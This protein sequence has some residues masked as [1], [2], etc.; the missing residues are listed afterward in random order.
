[1]QYG[2]NELTSSRMPTARK[3]KTIPS[4]S[5]TILLNEFL[6]LYPLTRAQML[7][8][9]TSLGNKIM[10]LCILSVPKK[11]PVQIVFFPHGPHVYCK[12]IRK[13]CS[14]VLVC[15]CRLSY[16]LPTA[17]VKEQTKSEIK[18]KLKKKR[19]TDEER[20]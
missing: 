8:F 16:F 10:Y 12:E 13:G 9:V 11:M 20:K 18:R 6:N 3:F 15:A 4:D 1:V 2:C 5:A 17:A 19:N 7:H 14:R